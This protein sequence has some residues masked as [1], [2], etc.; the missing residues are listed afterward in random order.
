MIGP[1]MQRGAHEFPTLRQGSGGAGAGE[2]YVKL[3]EAA[4]HDLV[5]PANQIRIMLDLVLQKHG[6][7]LSQDARTLLEFVLGASDRLQTMM[8]GLRA[9]TGVMSRAQQ[10]RHFDTNAILADAIKAL[11]QSIADSD[12]LITHDPLPEVW[13]D[14]S[15]IGCVFVSLIGNSIKFRRECRPEIHVSAATRERDWMF[16]VRDNGI[17]IDSE[18]KHRI[19]GLFSRINR[20]VYPGAGIGLAVSQAIMERHQG[21]I[22]VESEPGRG[23]T[24]FF[25]LPQPGAEVTNLADIKNPG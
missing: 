19:F 14:A 5:G 12:A 20:D 1:S 18:Q 16:S 7:E 3:N 17:G 15:Q 25:A 24:F 21:R 11:E 2:C 4:I 23:A 22:W 8:S 6:G 9:F 10:F 13:G